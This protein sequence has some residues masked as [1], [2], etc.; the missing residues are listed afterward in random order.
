MEDSLAKK[1]GIIIFPLVIMVI[2]SMLM[3]CASGTELNVSPTS[4]KAET[5]MP[6]SNDI[7]KTPVA[8]TTPT[9]SR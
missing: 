1:V 3:G 2:F 7:R 8:T 5:S 6:N 9:L 4:P